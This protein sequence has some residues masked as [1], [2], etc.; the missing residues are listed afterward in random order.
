MTLKRACLCF[1]L[2]V[3]TPLVMVGFALWGLF[4][5]HRFINVQFEAPAIDW[6]LV[7][8]PGWK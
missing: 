3:A 1:V 4:V 6:D 2:I 7:T 5:W 8:P